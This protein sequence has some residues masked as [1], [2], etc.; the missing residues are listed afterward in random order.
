M[1]SFGGSL[2]SLSL[3]HRQVVS[4]HLEFIFVAESFEVNFECITLANRDY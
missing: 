2:S 1:P 4:A 3:Y